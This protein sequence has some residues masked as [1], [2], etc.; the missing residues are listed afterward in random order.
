MPPDWGDS[1]LLA[2]QCGDPRPLAGLHTDA[3][4]VLAAHRQVW[5]VLRLEADDPWRRILSATEPIGRLVAAVVAAERLDPVDLS[6]V[7]LASLGE[8]EDRQRALIA[9]YAAYLSLHRRVELPLATVET[10]AM[11]LRELITLDQAAF[12]QGGAPG[13]APAHIAMAEEA[14]SEGVE[15]EALFRAC[16]RNLFIALAKRKHLVVIE[17]VSNLFRQLWLAMGID[18]ALGEQPGPC[19]AEVSA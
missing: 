8:L 14:G 15:N 7:L 12:R 11:S 13:P 4:A 3:E 19:R 16:L 9:G 17:D 1:L 2:L 18:A 10:L 5:E 6:Q